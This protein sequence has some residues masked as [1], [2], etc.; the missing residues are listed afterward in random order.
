MRIRKQIVNIESLLHNWESDGI[1]SG[2]TEDHTYVA[3]NKPEP[4][5]L[6]KEYSQQWDEAEAEI[7]AEREKSGTEEDPFIWDEEEEEQGVEESDRI[8]SE[9]AVS[10]SPTTNGH[11]PRDE[12]KEERTT[13]LSLA[14]RKNAKYKGVKM[15]PEYE[16][17]PRPKAVQKV[18]ENHS[19]TAL[20]VNYITRE[21]FGDLE[22]GDMEVAT[23]RVRDSLM[24]GWRAGLFDR[25]PKD[26]GYYT[27]DAKLLDKQ[28]ARRK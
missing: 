18:L 22:D 7:K 5:R 25:V 13:R 11:H 8:A 21:M 1:S 28:P 10:P 3:D 6:L 4:Q 9:E 19:G 23:V 26:P 24:R 15:L 16:V 14:A 27:F 2:I 17:M 12:T 20:H